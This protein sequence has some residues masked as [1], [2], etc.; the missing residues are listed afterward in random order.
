MKKFL[1]SALFLGFA[2]VGC[3]GG[4]SDSTSTPTVYEQFS[5][6]YACFNANYQQVAPT[7]V[8]FTASTMSS[9][10]GSSLMH[11]LPFLTIDSK[12][13]YGYGKVMPDNRVLIGMLTPSGI[14]GTNYYV[15]YVYSYPGTNTLDESSVVVCR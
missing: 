8:D 5:K 1:L 7:R 9:Y 3:G 15:S 13:N 2:L 6:N 10:N 4:G 12:G 11:T 14:S